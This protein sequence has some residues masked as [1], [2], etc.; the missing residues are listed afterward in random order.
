MLLLNSNMELA[1]EDGAVEATN[2]DYQTAKDQH[3]HIKVDELVAVGHFNARRS[4]T[5]PL[6]LAID[7]RTLASPSQLI[8]L[9]PSL[10]LLIGA[11]T[12]DDDHIGQTSGARG[13]RPGS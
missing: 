6:V 1:F 5:E 12:L 11:L 10:Q 3:L 2:V 4:V 9:R 8:L 13:P 7:L